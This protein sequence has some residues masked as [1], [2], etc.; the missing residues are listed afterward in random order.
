MSYDDWVTAGARVRPA[1]P[2]RVRAALGSGCLAGALVLPVGATAPARDAT[3]RAFTTDATFTV[4]D[5]VTGITVTLV[6]AGAGGGGG[7]GGGG[8]GLFKSG[9]GG[10]AG[11]GGGGGARVACTL[12]VTPG[13]VLTL[14]VG[15]GGAGAPGAACGA[16]ADPGFDCASPPAD[17]GT[18]R[19]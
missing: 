7:G 5:G 4:P 11:G 13:D 17:F 16:E 3:T 2:R 1:R 9:G 6:A 15:S 18:S 19:A 8:T 10:G 14:T 12:A